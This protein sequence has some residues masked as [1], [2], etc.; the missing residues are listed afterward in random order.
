MTTV[1]PGVDWLTMT[2]PEADGSWD[3]VLG[4]IHILND[5]GKAGNGIKPASMQGYQGSRCGGSFV[6]TRHDGYMAQISG[7][8]AD[9]AFDPL[10]NAEAHYTRLDLQVTIQYDTER[11]NQGDICYEHCTRHIDNLPPSK[12]PKVYRTTSNDGGYSL[13]IGAPSSNNRCC[14]YNKAKEAQTKQYERCWRYEIRVRGEL[15]DKWAMVLHSAT[16]ARTDSILA[17]VHTW[18]TG[19]G[20]YLPELDHAVPVTILP[21]ESTR[22]SDVDTK[23]NWL[24]TQV[25]P[26]LE[27]LRGYVDNSV[28]MQALGMAWLDQ[29]AAPAASTRHTQ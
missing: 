22:R 3:W 24:K 9:D 18:L 8:D 1:R 25:A 2:L 4:A 14:I 29:E 12:R 16:G 21:K 5:I 28:I 10:W 17:M 20:I 19:R 26:S 15:A 7:K 6:G 23:L 27:W 11:P 13:Y